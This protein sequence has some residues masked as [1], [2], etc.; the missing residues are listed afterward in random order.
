M[1]EKIKE[2]IRGFFGKEMANADKLGHDPFKGHC[3][4][5]TGKSFFD[6]SLAE[7]VGWK[8]GEPCNSDTDGEPCEIDFITI[9]CDRKPGVKIWTLRLIPT[10]MVC[11]TLGG[12]GVTRPTDMEDVRKGVK[13]GYEVKTAPTSAPIYVRKLHG[14]LQLCSAE[15]T[16]NSEPT[17]YITVVV[18]DEPNVGWTVASVH[19]GEAGGDIG[20]YLMHAVHYMRKEDASPVKG[21]ADG[22]EFDPD[23]V[24][25]GVPDWV[26]EHLV[27]DPAG[28]L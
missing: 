6:E 20:K 27:Q 1:I 19:P 11:E 4:A 15:V 16:L 24:V 14:C 23:L 28:V 2:L 17:E 10:L 26:F 8:P 9:A 22:D 3:D 12:R 5:S 7:Y 18:T 13:C 21:Y 25:G